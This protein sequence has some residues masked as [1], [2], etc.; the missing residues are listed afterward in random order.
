MVEYLRLIISPETWPVQNENTSI[1]YPVSYL[2]DLTRGHGMKLKYFCKEGIFPFCTWIICKINICKSSRSN[3]TNFK[4]QM[5][6]KW[7]MKWYDK[8][9]YINI[10]ISSQ[11]FNQYIFY[12][13]YFNMF[14]LS[15]YFRIWELN[16]Y[17]NI[18]NFFGCGNCIGLIWLPAP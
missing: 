3:N 17:Q 11:W 14:L 9:R 8:K 7:I 10:H 13:T 6:I 2:N 1:Q 16:F 15:F 18:S 12:K 4:Y 5:G